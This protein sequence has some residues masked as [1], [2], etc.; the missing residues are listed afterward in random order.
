[1]LP[2]LRL[3]SH[4]LTLEI[5]PMTHAYERFPKSMYQWIWFY[6]WH[7]A[8]FL[9]FF[10]PA[11]LSRPFLKKC[12]KWHKEYQWHREYWWHNEAN[13]PVSTLKR[14]PLLFLSY[15]QYLYLLSPTQSF[16]NFLVCRFL[17]K[18]SITVWSLIPMHF[19]SIQFLMTNKKEH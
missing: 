6:M 14:K 5:K 9:P 11:F 7:S 8:I 18:F 19:K 13:I 4:I 12:S 3:L 17:A 1:M 2:S 10:G 16:N 15:N